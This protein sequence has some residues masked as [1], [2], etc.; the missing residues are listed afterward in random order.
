[1]DR[2]CSQYF[3]KI[4]IR[5]RNVDIGAKVYWLS[6]EKG[7]RPGNNLLERPQSMVV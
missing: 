3:A 6:N 1:M 2:L 5:G 7:T 4:A